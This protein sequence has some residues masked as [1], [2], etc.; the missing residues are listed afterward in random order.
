MTGY[1]LQLVREANRDFYISLLF[2]PKQK[3]QAL[4]A[5][6]AFNIEIARIAYRVHDPLLGE[7]RL[8]WWRDTIEGGSVNSS[9]EN[10]VADGVLAA[11]SR[12][13]L[14]RQ[15]FLNACDARLFDLYDNVMQSRNDFEGYCGETTSAFIQLACQIVDPLGA[16]HCAN[17]SGH[18]GVALALSNILR[19]LPTHFANNQKFLPTELLQALGIERQV[20]CGKTADKT[21][22]SRA[23]AALIAW[24]REHYI[25]FLNAYQALPPQFR[26]AY[27]PMAPIPYYLQ[28]LERLGAQAFEKTTLFSPLR[29]QWI[30]T[31]TAISGRFAPLKTR[32][33]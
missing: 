7:I 16:H 31:K 3:H 17:A 24:A 32:E 14:P 6:T 11:M 30:I 29:R 23:L 28:K 12:F 5:I 25:Q 19:Q 9:T 10:P 27:L 21:K 8:R 1:S 20:L 22:Q 4:A 33:S 18:G 15:V 13:D 26:S 2:A